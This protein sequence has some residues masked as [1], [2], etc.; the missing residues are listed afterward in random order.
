MDIVSRQDQQ[1]AIRSGALQRDPHQRLDQPG[2]QHLAGDG[3][4]CLDHGRDIQ[5][6]NRGARRRDGRA[7]R[8]E[9]PRMQ[10]LELPDFGVGTPAQIAIAGVQQIG[11]SDLLEPARCV[12]TRRKLVGDRL[13]VDEAVGT[14]RAERIAAC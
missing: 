1:P 2:Q 13:V 9:Q 12:E 7:I 3:L 10:P 6:G 8:R 5:L 14:R 4:R 11:V